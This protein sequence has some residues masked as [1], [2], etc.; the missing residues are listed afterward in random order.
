MNE[1]L[2]IGL[3]ASVATLLLGWFVPIALIAFYAIR[4]IGDKEN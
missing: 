1:R 4:L 2:V 3:V